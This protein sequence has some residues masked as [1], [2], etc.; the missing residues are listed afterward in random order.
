[1]VCPRLPL[2]V[3]IAREG[4]FTP[5]RLAQT[6][7]V[8]NLLPPET[9]VVSAEDARLILR[10]IHRVAEQGHASA[11][12][13]WLG[14]PHTLPREEKRIPL[15]PRCLP[16]TGPPPKGCTHALVRGPLPESG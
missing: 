2:L 15:H 10:G 13:G 8:A 1:V 7:P 9:G 5:T 16:S 6:P 11:K 3:A 14:P 12:P 4:S